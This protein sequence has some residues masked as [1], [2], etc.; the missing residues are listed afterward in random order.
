M[1]P[2]RIRAPQLPRGAGGEA[3]PTVQVPLSKLSIVFATIVIFVLS[4]CSCGFMAK[5]LKWIRVTLTR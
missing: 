1:S 2:A 3:L 5:V 4:A